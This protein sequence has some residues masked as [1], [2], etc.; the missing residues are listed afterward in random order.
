MK[1]KLA[2]SIGFALSLLAVCVP[3]FAHHGNSAYDESK[4]VVLKE[5]TVTDF[6]W[7]NP[8]CLVLF[9]VK[10]DKGKVAH[11]TVESGSPSAL[12]NVGWNRYSLKPGDGITIYLHQSKLGSPTGRF[13]KLE[14]ADGTVLN[15]G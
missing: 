12:T 8:H 6:V 14:R 11:W 5:A 2:M 3:V 4:V 7:A 15:G 13:T 9:D 10:D 1:A